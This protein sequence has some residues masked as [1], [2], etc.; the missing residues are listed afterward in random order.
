MFWAQ[1]VLA[2]INHSLYGIGFLAAA[3][4]AGQSPLESFG[5]IFR[6]FT[7]VLAAAESGA[8]PD[9]DQLLMLVDH[10]GV[11]ALAGLLTMIPLIFVNVRLAPFVAGSAVENRLLLFGAFN[12]T[13]G[14]FWSIVG[15]Y[16]LL[17]LM[18]MV[19]GIAFTLISSIFEVLA[20]LGS[21]GDGILA[22]VGF[23]FAALLF[24]SYILYQSFIIGVQFAAPAVMYRRLKTG[25]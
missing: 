2:I 4:I 21:G 5:A 1:V 14:Q 7:I 13:K 9:P 8:E 20:A 12:L 23:V 15:F 25:A 24:V 11:F 19:I 22:L 3:T 18:L 16:I 17:L 10:I 6:F